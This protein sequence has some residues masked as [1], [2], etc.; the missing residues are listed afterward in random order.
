MK[1]TYVYYIC[2]CV[3]LYPTVTILSEYNNV[4]TFLLP[5]KLLGS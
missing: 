2:V 3:Y 1:I 5:Y 4:Y